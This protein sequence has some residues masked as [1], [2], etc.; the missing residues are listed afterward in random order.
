MNPTAQV[1]NTKGT[2]PPP[3]GPPQAASTSAPTMGRV[4]VAHA[5]AAGAP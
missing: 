5:A 2:P 4:A 3:T 1:A